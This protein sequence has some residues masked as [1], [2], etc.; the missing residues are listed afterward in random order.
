[1]EEQ[2][3]KYI[4]GCIKNNQR[5]EELLYKY[6]FAN[7]MKVCMR[8]HRNTFD[9]SISFNKAMHN[10]FSKLKM[11]RGDGAF[12]G[13]VQKIIINVYGNCCYDECKT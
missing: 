10:V 12:L 11:Y 8:Y 7:L 5:S 9:A 13:W 4:K 3:N 6:C 2:I 1:M